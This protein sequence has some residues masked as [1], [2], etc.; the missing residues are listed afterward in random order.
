MQRALRFEHVLEVLDLRAARSARKLAE[1][2]HVAVALW[3]E[4]DDASRPAGSA[5]L[6]EIM[7]A[8]ERLLLLGDAPAP[9]T[10]RPAPPISGVEK[11][12]GVEDDETRSDTSSS[13][14]HAA[15]WLAALGVPRRRR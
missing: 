10:E 3:S 1:R 11:S 8:A 14:E 13:A 6:H 2:M 12:D 15:A 9:S 7:E 5:E 4:A